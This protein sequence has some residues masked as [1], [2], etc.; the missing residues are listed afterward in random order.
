MKLL[1]LFKVCSKTDLILLRKVTRSYFPIVDEDFRGS[2]FQAGETGLIQHL[3]L[4]GTNHNYLL[5]SLT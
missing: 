1:E 2:N 5:T 4:K 3:G